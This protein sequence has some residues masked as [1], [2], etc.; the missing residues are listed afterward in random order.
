[1]RSADATRRGTSV[2]RWRAQGSRGRGCS[3]TAG[4]RRRDAPRPPPRMW[5]PLDLS[6]PATVSDRSIQLRPARC[7]WI[8]VSFVF[9][10]R[11]SPS[12]SSN[13]RPLDGSGGVGRMARKNEG[14]NS[15]RRGGKREFVIRQTPRCETRRIFPSS[16]AV[17]MGGAGDRRHP[18]RP[19]GATI[20]KESPNAQG[21]SALD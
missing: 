10:A 17:D 21:R 19:D 1:M 14:D 5:V 15:E 13:W 3:P 6:G 20:A 16:F 18:T 7:I 9:A 2:R 11:L 8:I 12:P 4:R